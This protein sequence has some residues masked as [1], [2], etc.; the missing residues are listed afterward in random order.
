MEQFPVGHHELGSI[1][2]L[3]EQLRLFRECSTDNE[4]LKANQQHL[5]TLLSHTLNTDATFH[6]A[7]ETLLAV[8]PFVHKQD[9]QSPWQRLTWDALVG[10]LNL[11]DGGLQAQVLTV[12]SH[13]QM[14][15]G[16]HRAAR[17][18]IENA[19]ERALEQNNE[20]ALLLAY[21]RFFEFFVFEPRD[22]TPADVVQ[23]VLELAA[24]VNEPHLSTQLH[25]A[26]AHFYNQWGDAERAL[27]HGEVAYALARY[28]GDK[29][30]LAR[31]AYLMV[32][33]CRLR[34]LRVA[35]HFLQVA[36]TTDFSSLPAHDKMTSLM[37]T[38]A[39][40]YEM[41]KFEE[42]AAGYSAALKLTERL[43]RPYYRASCFQGL[44]LAQIRL[45]R[46]D[47]ARV[48]LYRAGKIWA[49]RGNPYDLA[50]HRFT[51]GYLEG[52]AGNRDIALELLDEAVMLCDDIPSMASRDAL[53]KQILD[54]RQQ[55][56]DGTLEDFYRI[57]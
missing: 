7:V 1:E 11:K 22:I 56:V 9:D 5:E 17:Q 15:E 10:A 23:P 37:H 47:D 30:N 38:S 31:A 33:I 34:Y 40:Y 16:N 4:F 46:F 29:D 14:V 26:L 44:A 49:K 36:L 43:K 8:A 42:A 53:R 21:I 54:T 12:F 32:T 45:K 55:I 2:D 6:E 25:Y 20:V 35:K 24:R 28:H 39:M 50:N 3:K 57:T 41:G 51:Q 18:S 19:R 52:W 48:N 27:G 13:F